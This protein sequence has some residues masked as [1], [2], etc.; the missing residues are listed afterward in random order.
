M[1]K[2]VNHDERRRELGIALLEVLAKDGIDGVS[3]RTVAAQAGWSRGVIEHYF[4]TRDDLLLYAYRLALH[5][6]YELAMKEPVGDDPLDRLLSVLI[7]ALPIDVESS[8]DYRI[9]LGLLGRLADNPELAASLASDHAEYEARVVEATEAAIE[10]GA[11]RAAMPADALA[12]YLTTYLDGLTV[13][14]ALRL[15]EA[16]REG[17]DRRIRAFI[18]ALT[19]E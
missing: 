12:R 4:P 3:V 16:D 2:V 9:F 13:G 1:P 5:R 7:R 11:I 15:T 6:E 19:R 14:C 18:E 17:L 10:A 8:L